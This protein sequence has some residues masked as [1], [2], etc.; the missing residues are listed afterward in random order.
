METPL[1][2][3]YQFFQEK[4]FWFALQGDLEYQQCAQAARAR[5]HALRAALDEEGR[6]LLDAMLEEETLEQSAAERVLFRSAFALCR[7]LD[8]QAGT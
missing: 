1:D 3:L 4:R 7:E 5:E 8:R 2:S 6:R